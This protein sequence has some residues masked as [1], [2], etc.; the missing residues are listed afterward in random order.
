[1]KGELPALDVQG[2][3]GGLRLS[4]DQG[5]LTGVSAPIWQVH[6]AWALVSSS[7]GSPAG[8]RCPSW[9]LSRLVN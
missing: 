7:L 5:K 4:L 9:Q 3:T 6:T 8:G 1:M 2:L